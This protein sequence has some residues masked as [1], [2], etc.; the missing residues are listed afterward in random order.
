MAVSMYSRGCTS[1]SRHSVACAAADRQALCGRA[2]VPTAVQRFAQVAVA[3]GAAIV[4][5]CSGAM[6]RPEPVN[7]PD[8]LPKGEKT[9]VIDV[10]GFLTEGEEK[11]M[12]AQI[13]GIEQDTGFK[14]RVLAQ[15]YPETPGLAIRDYWGVDDNT[16]VFVADPGFGD[17]L[18]FNVGQVVDLDVPRSFWSRLAGKYGNKFYWQENGQEASI[19]AAVSAINT[20]LREPPGRFKCSQI[21][22]ADM[23]EAPASGKF[24]KFFK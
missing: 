3:S 2:A 21:Q 12:K 18:N 24:G 19:T 20:C 14:L 22:S 10:A 5:S 4:L 23:A 17:I 8:L 9:T 11:R 16:I 1:R 15:N 6:A 13:E 7:R